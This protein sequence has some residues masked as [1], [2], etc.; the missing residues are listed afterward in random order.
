VLQSIHS[1][2]KLLQVCFCQVQVTISYKKAFIN[3]PLQLYF[4]DV[5][6]INS[7]LRFPRDSF[8]RMS[9]VLS[10]DRYTK[11]LYIQE[12]PQVDLPVKSGSRN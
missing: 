11:E 6:L 12:D 1:D 5:K 3:E 8:V 4:V 2:Q 10:K 9:L 7:L